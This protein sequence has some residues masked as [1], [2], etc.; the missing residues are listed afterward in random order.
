M[1]W[2]SPRTGAIVAG[3]HNA[4]FTRNQDLFS[5]FRKT[6]AK[7]LPIPTMASATR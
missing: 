3:A 2:I 4:S 5:S 1:P 6:H 7:I